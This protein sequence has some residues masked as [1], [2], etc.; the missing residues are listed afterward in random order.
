MKSLR[1]DLRDILELDCNDR[2]LIDEP[3]HLIDQLIHRSESLQTIIQDAE[4]VFESEVW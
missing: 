4:S 1:L 3:D 2:L